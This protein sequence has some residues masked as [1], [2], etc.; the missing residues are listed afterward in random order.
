VDGGFVYRGKILHE[1]DQRFENTV[2]SLS[3]YAFHSFLYYSA[4]S[5]T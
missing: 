2:P 5:G 4:V 1:K 3:L